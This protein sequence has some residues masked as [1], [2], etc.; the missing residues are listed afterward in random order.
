MMLHRVAGED[1]RVL[2][3][4]RTNCLGASRFYNHELA[5]VHS[6]DP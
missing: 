5:C 6:L 2:F 1:T 3:V 4:D